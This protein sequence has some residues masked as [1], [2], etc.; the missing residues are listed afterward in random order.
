MTGANRLIA[1][2][3]VVTVGEPAGQHDGVHLVQVRVRVPQRHGLGTHEPDRS[4]G[5]PVVERPGERDDADPRHQ[6]PASTDS[7]A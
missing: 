7:S 5:V 4:G 6:A 2:A 1:R 3:Q